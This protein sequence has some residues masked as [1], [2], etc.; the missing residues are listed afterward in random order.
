MAM[1][2]DRNS[3]TVI[4]HDH[5]MCRGVGQAS[6]IKLPLSTQQ[7]WVPGGTKK[8]SAQMLNFPQRRWDCIRKSS[9]TRGVNCKVC[10]TQWGFQTINRHVYVYVYVTDITN[11]YE[12][13][14]I[15][16]LEL[17]HDKHVF[18]YNVIWWHLDYI[19][20]N[21][22]NNSQL[23]IKLFNAKRATYES[24]LKSLFNLSFPWMIFY[25]TCH[26]QIQ[27]CLRSLVR[28]TYI[29]VVARITS[30]VID[31]FGFEWVISFPLLQMSLHLMHFLP[32]KSLISP[33]LEKTL[34]LTDMQQ[35]KFPLPLCLVIWWYAFT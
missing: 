28:V 25:P 21:I 15:R 19:I 26:F 27:S 16:H 7:W 24:T 13:V 5:D 11:I 9:N 29:I 8:L 14:Y 32:V 20:S 10:W 30:A 17:R 6:H 2:S 4:A 12:L 1:W 34:K 3:H 23:L 33:M 31:E 35:I 18:V 22:W